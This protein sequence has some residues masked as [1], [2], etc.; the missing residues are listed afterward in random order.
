MIDRR[1]VYVIKI[2]VENEADIISIAID[3]HVYKGC[4]YYTSGPDRG[5]S[6]R[7]KMLKE[8]DTGFI[9]ISEQAFSGEWR[10]EQLTIEAFKR[11]YFKNILNR[12]QAEA[13]VASLQT[14]EDLWE[15]YRKLN[16]VEIGAHPADK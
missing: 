16:W 4:L 2:P 13:M 6:I 11:K 1:A 14:T 5:H 15:Y 7:G 10:A 12:T 3:V 8:T 9:W